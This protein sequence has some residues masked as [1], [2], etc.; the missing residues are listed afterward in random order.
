EASRTAPNAETTG[1]RYKKPSRRSFAAACGEGAGCLAAGLCRGDEARA[2]T[3]DLSDLVL[4]SYEAG[5]DWG[6]SDSCTSSFRSKTLSS[7]MV[8]AP[9][10]R[11]G[12][13][14]RLA[15]RKRNCIVSISNIPAQA[16]CQ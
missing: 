13:T 12:L 7:N 10:V 3:S 5:A 9:A 14:R 6:L 15:L 16:A 2:T 8:A 4:G 1:R 11:R